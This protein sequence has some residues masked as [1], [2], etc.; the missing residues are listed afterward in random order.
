M[1]VSLVACALIAIACSTGDRSDDRRP[2]SMQ[3]LAEIV[4]GTGPRAIV[5]STRPGDSVTQVR[6]QPVGAR[7]PSPV[8]LSLSHWPDGEVRGA[9]LQDDAHL[10][11]VAETAPGADRSFAASL[12]V[13]RLGEAPR[14]LASDVVVASRPLPLPDGGV[15]VQRGHA[16]PPPAAGSDELRT[17]EL[18]I[19]AYD[20]DGAHTE[21]HRFSGYTTHLAGVLD[22]ELLV[23]RVTHR[24]AD[25]VALDSDGGAL[26]VLLA[27]LPAM[28]RDFSVDADAGTLLFANHDDAGWFVARLHV[29]SGHLDEV[30]RTTDMRATPGS[31][32]GGGV[33]LNDG[34]GGR[35]LFGTGPDRPL[36]P[37]FDEV[38]VRRGDWV[39]LEHH[40]PGA[41]SE[42]WLFQ[43]SSERALR[44]PLTA[45]AR[46]SIAGVLP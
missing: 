40:V 43:R 3:Q 41:F 27:D 16:G 22:K 21:L 10:A 2:G 5:L 30:M 32:P 15:A 42:P 1:R 44:L 23:Y 12:W 25:I 4:E 18:T 38:R 28:A 11:L 20:V 19:D 39:G 8:T 33:L 46:H 13:A 36:G 35:V 31:W 7:T 17:D 6:L 9:L 34:A 24:H 14:Q 29:G 26:R 45:G 37:G